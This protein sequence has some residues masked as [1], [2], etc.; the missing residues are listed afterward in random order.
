VRIEDDV[1]V[2]DSGFEVLTKAVPKQID[3]V[4]ALRREAVG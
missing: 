4:E 1:L 3:G 2:T